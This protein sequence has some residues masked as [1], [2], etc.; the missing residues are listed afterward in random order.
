M[1]DQLNTCLELIHAETVL[2]RR[3]DHS[4][5]SH[6]GIGIHDYVMLQAI[7]TA[8][9]GRIRRIDLANELAMTASGV[10]RALHPLERM[11]LVDRESDPR[12]A[13]AAYAVL[14]S[15]GERVFVE[16]TVTAGEV[17]GSAL[18]EFDSDTLTTVRG[19]LAQI[20]A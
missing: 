1:S 11:G 8:P 19:A 5:G 13:R 18:S 4:L 6:H 2:S 14:T 3:F 20:S 15:A 16:S 9:A 12:D 7:A 10:T 17:A